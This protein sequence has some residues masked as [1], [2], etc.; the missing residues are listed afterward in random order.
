MPS[1]S[2]SVTPAPASAFSTTGTITSMCRR[3][4]SSGT[5]PPYGAWTS[6]CEATT[7]ERTR[8]P[9][10]RIAADVSSHEVSMPSTSLPITLLVP[11]FRARVSENTRGDVLPGA[12]APDRHRLRAIPSVLRLRPGR[13]RRAHLRAGG[14]AQLGGRPILQDLDRLLQLHV[15]LEV[16]QRIG[17]RQRPLFGD[18]LLRRLDHHV[19]RD[20]LAVDRAALGREVLRGRQPKA[21]AVGQRDDRLHR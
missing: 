5:T 3:D 19:R 7:F 2:P 17:R 6:S 20:A 18:R 9:S 11:K 15:L 14:P 12:E 1:R 21:G 8:R 13:R 10:A 16:L 4:A